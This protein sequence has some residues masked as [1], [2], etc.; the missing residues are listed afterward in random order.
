MT[1]NSKHISIARYIAG[2]LIFV[3]LIA[4]CSGSSSTNQQIPASD[5]VP[6]PDT[7]VAPI[8]PEN[9]ENISKENFDKIKDGMSLSEVEMIIAGTNE[10]VS[11][12]QI[13]DKK[14]EKYKWETVDSTRAIEVTFENDKVI[15]K[16]DTNLE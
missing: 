11:T 8:P 1:E 6:P 13:D 3:V 15:A 4:G 10:L 5:D 16:K 9:A 12:E 14:I 2:L 7:L